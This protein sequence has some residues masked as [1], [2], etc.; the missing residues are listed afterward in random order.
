MTV[1]HRRG[2]TRRC[3]PPGRFGAAGSELRKRS[4]AG[5]RARLRLTICVSAIHPLAP[6]TLARARRRVDVFTPVKST[7]SGLPVHL[8]P[9]LAGSV[10]SST[11]VSSASRLAHRRRSLPLRLRSYAPCECIHNCARLLDCRSATEL[12]L[13]RR[14]ANHSSEAGPRERLASLP[15]TLWLHGALS[16]ARGRC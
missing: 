7:L 11:P 15:S 13:V 8:T 12:C 10:D 4:R 1:L 2:L 16:R 3:P 5:A 9:L 14:S 6:W